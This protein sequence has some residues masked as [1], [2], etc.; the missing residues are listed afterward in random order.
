MTRLAI[1]LAVA[2][3]LALLLGFGVL[4]MLTVAGVLDGLGLA[5]QVGT[6]GLWGAPV[7]A[8]ALAVAW[9]PRS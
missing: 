1:G 4:P 7:A 6:A 8:F 3:V 5:V 9:R 2:D